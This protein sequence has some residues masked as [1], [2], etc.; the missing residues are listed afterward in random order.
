MANLTKQHIPLVDLKAQY[1]QIKDKVNDAIER[2]LENTSFIMGK[3]V[4]EF[5]KMFAEYCGAVHCVG[6]SSGTAAL[7]LALIACGVGYGD[8]VITSPHTFIA[9]AEAISFCGAVPVFVDIDPRTYNIDPTLIERAITDR[10]KAIIPVHLYGQPADMDPI[11]SIANQYGLAVIEDAA[12]AHGA[13]YKG[14]PIGTIGD[15]GC[16]SFYPGKNLG[17]Y[18][19]GGAIVT[20]DSK[21]AQKI[22]ALRNHGRLPGNK[23]LHDMVGYGERLDSLQAAIL[24]V[25]LE[26]L[27]IWIEQRR[28]KAAYYSRMLADCIVETPYCPG[29][30]E[31]A[32]HLYVLRVPNR[33]RI[34]Q[35]LRE[36][37]IGAGIHYPIPV[38]LQP[39]Y[40]YL[41]QKCGAYP[42]SEQAADQ[43]LS[44]PIFPEL[45]Q[46][47]QDRVIDTLIYALDEHA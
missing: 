28:E 22:A 41:N 21:I 43:I 15:V 2:V 11:I 32:Y 9:T 7:Q 16:F 45:T 39:A 14:Q 36:Q 8:E 29:S 33:D 47:Q 31:H 46:A 37:G 17:A 12:Q 13:I 26:Y 35:E 5:E 25:K 10:T 38:H 40:Q 6:V 19:D 42:I 18:G 44:L 34:L 1:Q 3:E 24:K 4:A 23:Y 20:N 30:I 27:T